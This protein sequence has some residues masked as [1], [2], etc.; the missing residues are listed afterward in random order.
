MVKRERISNVDVLHEHSTA[1]R[2]TIQI[3]ERV[4]VEMEAIKEKELEQIRKHFRLE[5]KKL[6]DELGQKD[7]DLRDKKE[8]LN[9]LLIQFKNLE[10]K[11]GKP[12]KLDKGS[13]E[14]GKCQAT[15]DAEILLTE[16]IYNA[17]NR[18]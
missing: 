10:K 7:R 17:I 4:K 8:E 5:E 11:V 15:L 16:N 3:R 13:E 18:P 2:E 6:Q 12:S 1:R 14:N 9:R